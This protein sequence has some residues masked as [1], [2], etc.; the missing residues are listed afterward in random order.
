M[1]KAIFIDCPNFLYELYDEDLRSIVPELSINVGDPISGDIAELLDGAVVGINDHTFMDEKLL[2]SCNA[3]RVI[4]FMGTGASSYIDLNAAEKYGINVRTIRNYGNRSVAEHTIA[5]MFSAGR[6]IA[7]M[8]RS[9]RD[10]HWETLDGIEF[11]HKI[12]GIVG[13]GGIG[14][15]MIRLG[16]A[17]GMKVLAWNRSA[18]D[19]TLPCEMCDLDEIFS[20]S[21][22]VS[23]H[24]S[25]TNETKNLVDSR[26]IKLLKPHSIFLNSA[27]GGIVDESAL[28]KAL[29]EDKLLHAGLDVF[30]V[31]PL[32]PE[33]PLLEL[34]NV[35]LTSHAGFMTGEASRRL[36]RTALEIT[37]KELIAV[38]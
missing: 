1:S 38:K 31:E 27:R 18:V 37:N 4:V 24:L 5:L 34:D 11:E 21:D 22:V 9:L 32:E 14:K 3:L 2:G 19:Q 25:L 33:N 29:K 20:R 17:L 7:S 10:G 6:Q 15:E 36:L 35:T 28:V 23:L 8:D 26:R 30:S 13:V 12:L 16:N